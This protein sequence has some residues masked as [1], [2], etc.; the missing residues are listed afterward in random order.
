M[1]V[2]FKKNTAYLSAAGAAFA[3]SLALSPSPAAADSA[4]PFMVADLGSGYSV[5]AAEGKCGEGKCGSKGDGKDDGD[6][7]GGEGKCGEGKC[8]SG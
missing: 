1:S 7:K 5:A 4:N 3:V 6:K 2:N 8:A